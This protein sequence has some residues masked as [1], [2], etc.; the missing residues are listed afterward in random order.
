MERREIINKAR[1]KYIKTGITINITEALKLYLEKDATSKEKIPLMITT[2]V[3][4]Q[5]KQELK[6]I[7]PTCDDCS[8]DLYMQIN[9][10]CFNTG[11]RY[12]TAWVCSSCNKIEYSDK[13]PEQWL[14]IL[15][16]ENRQ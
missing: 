4:H 8:G 1:E 9:A 10:I 13:T 12:P 5:I 3:H 11:I 15:K 7:R 14:E 2:P 16:N 6:T